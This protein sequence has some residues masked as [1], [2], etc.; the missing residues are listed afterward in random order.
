MVRMFRR[1][2]S[3]EDCFQGVVRHAQGRGRGVYI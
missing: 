2:F 3:F 1:I